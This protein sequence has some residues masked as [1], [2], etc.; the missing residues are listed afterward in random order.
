M[1]SKI[2]IVCLIINLCATASG[3]SAK[4]YNI[5]DADCKIRFY[6]LPN[7]QG[8]SW[9]Y[10]GILWSYKEDCHPYSCSGIIP[11][12]SKFV[13][14]SVRTF[15][16]KPENCN[17]WIIC[18]KK[19]IRH[20]RKNMQCTNLT[21]DPNDYPDIRRWD[22]GRHKIQQWSIGVTKV[23]FT[24]PPVFTS[25]PFSTIEKMTG[26]SYTCTGKKCNKINTGI[27]DMTISIHKLQLNNFLVLNS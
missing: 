12:R 8:S 6:E 27:V 21:P 22:I 24:K 5:D 26:T 15:A 13:P 20:G 17:T 2:R 9:T 25:R 19:R 1:D 10:D 11:N 3:A 18:S 23:S 16:D 14:E 7:Y 4:L